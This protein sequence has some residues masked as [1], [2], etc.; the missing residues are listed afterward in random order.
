MKNVGR[1]VAAAALA[2]IALTGCGST[3]V[4]GQAE[5]AQQQA[6][7]PTLDPCSIPDEALRTA[8]ADPASVT[9][10]IVGVK[11]PG[12]SLCRWRGPDYFVTIF[13]TGQSVDTIRSNERFTDFT[14]IDLA[15]REAF[16]FRETTDKRN[17]FCDVLFTSGPDTVMIKSSY[18]TGKAP[19]EGPCSLAVRNARA[20]ESSIPR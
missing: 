17:E 11:Q 1:H 8:G 10:D 7:E 12:W 16:T 13:A 19:A 15:G 20:L 5:T 3:S 6:E 4:E 18:L 9:R 14:P 2:V